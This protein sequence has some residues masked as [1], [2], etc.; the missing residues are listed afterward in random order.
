MQQDFLFLLKV[1]ICEVD[2]S[3]YNTVLYSYCDKVDIT[4][5]SSHKIRK[6][7]ISNLIENGFNPKVITKLVGHEDYQTTL[8]S[9]CRSLKSQS[10]LE[11]SLDK[12]SL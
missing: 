12:C 1:H 3:Y 9:Y 5:K 10:E 11:N 8:K 7:F 4:R 6:T 2:N